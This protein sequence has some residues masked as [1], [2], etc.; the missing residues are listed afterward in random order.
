MNMI[1]L[2]N[3]IDNNDKIPKEWMNLIRELENY[4]DRFCVFILGE[5]D[6][7]K[8]SFCRFL[9]SS[10]VAKGYS[11]AW[12]DA[13]IGQ[14][15]I[16]PPASV[17]MKIISSGEEKDNPLFFRFV[18]SISP[19]GHLLQSLVAVRSLV[20]KAISQKVRGIILD[21]TGFVSGRVGIEFKF[22]K[23][24]LV[25]PTHLIALEKRKEL[26]VLLKNFSRRKS[27]FLGFWFNKIWYR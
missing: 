11:L 20:D 14:S 16:G 18:G 10:L 27:L 2:V 25:N 24:E 13:D 6:S 5:S 26:E 22:Q 17:G 21:T 3:I 23:I 12:I 1:D 15:T 4:K 19:T 8:T 9:I 7:G